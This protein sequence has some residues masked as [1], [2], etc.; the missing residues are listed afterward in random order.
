MGDGHHAGSAPQ[1]ISF[2][3]GQMR[4]GNV[5][6]LCARCNSLK[7]DLPADIWF[8]ALRT[9]RAMWRQSHPELSF[10]QKSAEWSAE[11]RELFRAYL[12][13]LQDEHPPLSRE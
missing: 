6:L 12:A 4:C 3:R 8:Q 9:V 11:L 7:A 2:Y 1:R 5:Q 10:R 13:S